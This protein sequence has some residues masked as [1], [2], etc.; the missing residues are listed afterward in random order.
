[1][2]RLSVGCWKAPQLGVDEEGN[3]EN[4]VAIG[5]EVGGLDVVLGWDGT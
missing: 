3:G 4:E 5:M 2:R 1:M